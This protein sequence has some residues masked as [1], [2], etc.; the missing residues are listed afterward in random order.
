M[1]I[2]DDK[3]V[4]S[5]LFSS[6]FTCNLKKC[7][8]A[9]CWEGDFGAPLEESEVSLINESLPHIREYLPGE[10]QTYLDNNSGICD[11]VGKRGKTTA[12]MPDG[13]CVFLGFDQNGIGKCSFEAAWQAGITSF[14]KPVS[15]HLY[16]IRVSLFTDGKTQALNYDRWEICNAACILGDQLKM[17][18]FRF[19]KE[20]IE[21]KYG[22]E[23]YEEL[24][25]IYSDFFDEN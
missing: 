15:C 24:E 8:G 9:C 5:E 23:F 4:S 13:R 14:R 17:P 18:V 3:I 16:P 22:A 1:F 2:V 19:L 20:A 25:R 7:K 11:P 21:R 10:A 6:N 12:L